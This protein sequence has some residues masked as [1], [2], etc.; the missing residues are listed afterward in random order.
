MRTTG[1]RQ[2]P[3][4]LHGYCFKAVIHGRTQQ[5][6]RQRGGLTQAQDPASDMAPAARQ[7][8]E[9]R[10]RQV[11]ESAPNAMVMTDAKGRIELVNVEAER[12]FG[13]AR[14]EL[15]G[16]SVEMLLPTRFRTDHAG[17]RTAFRA[18]PRARRMGM[19]RNLLGV[20]KDG[21]EFPVEIGL[22]PIETEDGTLVLAAI[23]DISESIRQQQQVAEQAGELKRSNEELER[24]RRVS[25]EMNSK[26]Q[27]EIDERKKAELAAAAAKEQ[28]EHASEAKTAFLTNMSHEIR[29]PM[30]GILGMS[31]LLLETEMSEEQRQF[32]TAIR[33]SAN[34]LLGLLNDILDIA[35]LEA[36]RL[37]LENIDFDLEMLIDGT[38]E[39]IAVKAVEKDIEIC[40]LVD[41]SALHQYHGDPT[42]IRQILL[43]LIGNAVKFTEA[44]S[45]TVRAYEIPPDN[46][47]TTEPAILRIDVADTGIGFSEEGLSRLFKTFS[48]ADSSITRRFGGSGLGLAISR[49]LADLMGGKIEASSVQGRGSTFSL[50]VGL[51]RGAA[52]APPSPWMERLTGRRVLIADDHDTA[53]RALRRQLERVGIEVTDV[54]DGFSAFAE[55]R[56]AAAAGRGFDAVLIDQVMPGMSGEELAQDIEKVA[57]LAEVKLILLSPTGLSR[58]LGGASPARISAIMIKPPSYKA[59]IACLARVVLSGEAVVAKEE[60]SFLAGHDARARQGDALRILLAEDNVIN[61]QV[62]SGILKRAGYAIDVVDDGLAAVEAAERGRYDIILMDLQMPVM[63]GVEATDFIRKI[64]GFQRTPIIAM[65]AHAMRGTREE[66]LHAGMDDHIAKPIDPREFL[67]VVRRWASV[68]DARSAAKTPQTV[69][70]PSA[71]PLVD[72]HCLAALRVSME[73]SDFDAFVARAPERL[74]ND[75]DRL[76]HAFDSGDFAALEREAHKLISS[77][78]TVGAKALSSLAV[79]LEISTSENDRETV[80]SVMRAIGDK[81]PATLVALRGKH[82]AAV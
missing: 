67:A 38:L 66:C 8:M 48:Q 54:N 9:E 11:V 40:A 28:A 17:M 75:L 68:A 26:L 69:E 2:A 62:A 59:V 14:A 10:F 25:T 73:A 13:Y 15:L 79:Q 36:L 49:Q 12:I 64:D 78:G 21:S 50:V 31:S 6:P 52:P 5:T 57:A 82:G 53:R 23:I 74:Q 41:D 22:S 33:H 37:E 24:S 71:S 30:N 55:L 72:E 34:S 65:T 45:V 80:D 18:D 76:H 42:R 46:G 27:L 20:K 58:K 3:S 1:D 16:Q 19:G 77:A 47:N 35:K 44:G 61:Q 43:N 60:T 81:A 7:R 39:I 51:P 29:T 56:R 70:E 4:Y 63:S 32:A